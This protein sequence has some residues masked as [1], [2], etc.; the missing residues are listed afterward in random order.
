MSDQGRCPCGGDWAVTR[1][2]ATKSLHSC[3][4]C[5][6]RLEITA[7]LSRK[8]KNGL[9]VYS[10]SVREIAP[11]ARA[12]VQIT[13]D[14]AEEIE[15]ACPACGADL[16]LELKERVGPVAFF[17]CCCSSCGWDGHAQAEAVA[18]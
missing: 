14:S 5:S 15:M 6:C 1:L 4:Q 12:V 10:T 3:T 11:P 9:N 18:A 2:T 16:D 13:A 8:G 17:D 7:V